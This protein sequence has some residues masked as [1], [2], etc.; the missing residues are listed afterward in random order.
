L[1][2]A[3]RYRL[4]LAKSQ[5][6]DLAQR[7]AFVRMQEV[8]A[9]RGQRLDD[10][11]YRMGAGHQKLLHE[12]RRRLEIAAARVRH[13][14]FRRSLAVTRTKLEAGMDALARSMRSQLAAHQARLKQATATLEALSP[15]KILER[16][17][18][19]IFDSTGMLVKDAAQLSPGDEISAQVARGKFT[20]EVKKTNP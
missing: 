3:A 2:R 18:A 16:G 15:I 8:I 17:Y 4:L 19:L 9:R 20:A 6:N 13:F 1:G 7:G 11:I 14:D 10:L 5:L 12:Y